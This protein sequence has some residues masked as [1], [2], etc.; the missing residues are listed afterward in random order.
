VCLANTRRPLWRGRE[1]PG[2]EGTVH[3]LT[4]DSVPINDHPDQAAPSPIP[5]QQSTRYEQ[6]KQKNPCGGEILLYNN[7]NN[8]YYYY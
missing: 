4:Q 1:V 7:N 6:M 3:R 8:N 5:E 2:G